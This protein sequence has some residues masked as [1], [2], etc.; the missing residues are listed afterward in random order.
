MVA[1][2]WEAFTADEREA[3]IRFGSRPAPWESVPDTAHRLLK[4][5]P[6]ISL[7]GAATV[8]TIFRAAYAELASNG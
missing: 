4:T 1:E 8:A 6:Q 2:R 5:D 7:E 3:L